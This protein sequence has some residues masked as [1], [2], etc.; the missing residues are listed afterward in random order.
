MSSIQSMRKGLIILGILLLIPLR[1]FANPFPRTSYE[2][3][4]QRNMRP[5]P[6][7][8]LFVLIDQSVNFDN[9][10]RSKALELVSDWIADGRAVEVYAFSSAVPGR[11]TMRI[12]GGR[13]DDTPTDY[14][15]DNLRRSDREMF[16]VM[17]ARQK[18][19]AKRVILNSML[20]AF[21]GSRSEIHHTDIVRTVREISDY[22]HRYP[23][24]TK[25]VFLVS[26][27]LENS[28]IASFYYNNRIRAIAPD[29]ELAAVAAKNMIGDFGGNVKVYILG[30][31][32]YTVD[33]TK[34]QSENYL[35]SD[36]ISNIANFWYKYF[37]RSRTVVMEIG[38]P[39]MFGA[40]R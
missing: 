19:L 17:H 34:P 24:G 28:Q 27:M 20:Q 16:N 12:T 2:A 38:K 9:T 36:R 29:R 39:M 33:R 23:A 18:T 6:S 4:G 3:L 35:D 25:S 13:I 37:T 31:G 21:N 14:F 40:L 15:I 7:D 5:Y 8:V 11:Y 26:D 30:L 32:Y 10:I 1:L 22:I